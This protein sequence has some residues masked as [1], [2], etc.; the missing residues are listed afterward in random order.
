MYLLPPLLTICSAVLY[1]L[2]FP[3]FSFWPLAWVALAPFFLAASLVHPRLAA[4]YGVFW[5]VA[6]A[7]GVAWWLPRML[8]N[9]FGFSLIVG[10]AGLLAV[11]GGLAGIYFGTFAAWLSWLARR[12]AATDPSRRGTR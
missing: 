2:S 1:A 3:P 11:G 9:Y 12:R 5:G 6:V 7:C 10:W 4:V 8:A